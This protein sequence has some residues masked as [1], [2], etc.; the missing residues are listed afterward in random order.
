MVS[1]HGNVTPVVRAPAGLRGLDVGVVVEQ[2][3]RLTHVVDVA[4]N[5]A[6]SALGKTRGNRLADAT[7]GPVTSATCPAWDSEALFGGM[8]LTLV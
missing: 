4:E 3:A 5:D 1:K 2:V 7:A 6:G 8:W